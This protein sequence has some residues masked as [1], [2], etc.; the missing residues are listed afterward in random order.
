MGAILY[1]LRKIVSFFFSN[2]N[3]VMWILIH[4]LNKS[5]NRNKIWIVIMKNLT[6]KTK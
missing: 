3:G 1:A 5:N 4:V 6:K 2:F